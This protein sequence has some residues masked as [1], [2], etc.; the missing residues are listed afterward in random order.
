MSIGPDFRMVEL[1]AD[2]AAFAN[3]APLRI[4]NGRT[5]ILFVPGSPVKVA[6]YEW[7]ML[8]K[9]HTTPSGKTLFAI[10][11]PAPAVA[12]VEAKPKVPAVEIE[13]PEE[14]K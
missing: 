2:G 12:P 11:I 14:K 5:S 6:R 4:S 13:T 10:S 8:L 9:N 7:E 3:G 1:T